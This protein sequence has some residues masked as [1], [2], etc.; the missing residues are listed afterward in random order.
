MDIIKPSNKAQL[1]K[2]K[3]LTGIMALIIGYLLIDKINTG[4]NQTTLAKKELIIATVEQG[5][6]AITINGYG[7]LASKKRQ[8]VTA[9]SRATVKEIV[10]KPGAKVKKDSVIAVLANPELIKQRENAEYALIEAQG[11]LRQLTLN[12]KRQLLA[13]KAQRAE[14]LSQHKAIVLRL[15]AQQKLIANGIVSQLDYQSIRLQESQ[16]K[17]RVNILEQATKQL[18]LINKE[19]VHIQL[20]RIKQ[21]QSQ[22]DSAKNRLDKLKVKA[23]FEGVLQTLSVSLGQSLSAGEEVAV[24]GSTSELIA[25]VQISQTQVEKLLI[26][27]VVEIDTRLDVIV[28][29]IQRID[30]IVVDNTVEIEVKLPDILPKSARPQQNID[31]SIKVKT[32]HNVLYIERPANI[33]ANAVTNLYRLN[34]NQTLAHRTELMVGE[35]STRYIELINGIQQGQQYIISDLSNYQQNEIIIN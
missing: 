26:G 2:A 10:L 22:V 15:A 23:N 24:I 11:N 8:L 14:L 17:E 20:E 1:R 21:R 28:G 5:D 27:Q 31:A 30:P 7:Y 35:K 32:L 4:L 3:C 6:I 34:E 18:I 29:E 9:Y 33:V 13:E 12:H 25:L 16:L 19:A